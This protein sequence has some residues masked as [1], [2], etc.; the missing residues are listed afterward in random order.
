M[1][2]L[3]TIGLTITLVM[4]LHSQAADE[5]PLDPNASVGQRQRIAAQRDLIEANY[6]QAQQS[7][8]KRFAVSDCL[9][10]IR[11]ERRVVMDE[12]RRQERVL[13]DSDRQTKAAA[14]LERLQK[15]DS[16]ERQQTQAL[17]GRQELQQ[18]QPLN[19]EKSPDMT[20]KPEK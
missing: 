5:P 8:A 3:R 19:D 13:N 9:T 20:T 11:R 2:V 4:S 18:S 10:Q 17:Q 1:S 16:A 6:V 15:I 14:A 7:C 12:L